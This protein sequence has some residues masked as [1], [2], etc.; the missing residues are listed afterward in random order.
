MTDINEEIVEQYLKV[1][2]H[3]FYI[4]DISFQVPRKKSKKSQAI[5]IKD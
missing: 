4:G 2:K 1:V 5:V 3:C